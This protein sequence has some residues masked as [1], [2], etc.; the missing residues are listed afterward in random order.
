[1]IMVSASPFLNLIAIITFS[2]RGLKGYQIAPALFPKVSLLRLPRITA[3]RVLLTPQENVISKSVCPSVLVNQ[4][5]SI[6]KH[7]TKGV[8]SAGFSILQFYSAD[9]GV[10]E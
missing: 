1:M 10:S 9:A 2:K 3:L 4:L 6:A 8:D 7:V 5:G